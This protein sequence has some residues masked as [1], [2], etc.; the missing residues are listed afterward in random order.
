MRS[1][2][3]T[4]KRRPSRVQWRSLP[5]EPPRRVWCLCLI[6]LITA[7][8]LWF[9]P[10]QSP[11]TRTE[12]TRL[13]AGEIPRSRTGPMVKVVDGDTIDVELDARKI[14]VRYIGMNILETKYP[15]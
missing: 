14:R 11:A 7:L 10:E 5:H 8:I 2:S 6:G 9:R 13:A 4:R 3:Q 12:P 15:T 1:S